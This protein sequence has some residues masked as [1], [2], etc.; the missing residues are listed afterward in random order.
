MAK[1]EKCGL[2][3]W[4]YEPKDARQMAR[5]LV[6]LLYHVAEH[7]PVGDDLTPRLVTVRRQIDLGAEGIADAIAGWQEDQDG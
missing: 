7:W 1:C 3:D 6:S 2:S 4:R 5:S